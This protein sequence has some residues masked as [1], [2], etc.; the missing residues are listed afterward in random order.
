M[1]YISRKIMLLLTD[2]L[3]LMQMEREVSE[4]MAK[5][6]LSKNTPPPQPEA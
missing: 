5:V 4:K 1:L 6:D 2:R 3:Y